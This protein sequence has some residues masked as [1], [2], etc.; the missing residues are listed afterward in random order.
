MTLL[1]RVKDF[2]IYFFFLLWKREIRGWGSPKLCLSIVLERL[3]IVLGVHALWRYFKECADRMVAELLFQ[4]KG[5]WFF[6]ASFLN[7]TSVA[8]S[9]LV[10]LFSFAGRTG[11][12]IWLEVNNNKRQWLAVSPTSVMVTSV[13][14]VC[15]QHWKSAL[16]IAISLLLCEFLLSWHQEKKIEKGRKKLKKGGHQIEVSA[17]W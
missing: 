8:N 3:L 11:W 6:S 2:L 1:D 5:A 17:L 14:A 12:C 13:L 7:V 10:C 16:R 9:V 15:I 4:M